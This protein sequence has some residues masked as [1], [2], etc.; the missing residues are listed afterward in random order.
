MSQIIAIYELAKD[1]GRK[2]LKKI[3]ESHWETGFWL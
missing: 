3:A 1:K 2:S